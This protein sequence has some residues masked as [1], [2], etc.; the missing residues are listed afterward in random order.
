MQQSSNSPWENGMPA[1]PR[2]RMVKW[3]EEEQ[4]SDPSNLTTVIYL[5]MAFMN[6]LLL[7]VA[8]FMFIL[9]GEIWFRTSL[10]LSGLPYIAIENNV[11]SGNQTIPL[12]VALFSS[13]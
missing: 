5:L 2:V 9:C 4:P 3:S 7:D 13:T 1:G 8:H 11:I 12:S 6:L 10:E